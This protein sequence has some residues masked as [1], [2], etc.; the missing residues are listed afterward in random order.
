MKCEF[1]AKLLLHVSGRILIQRKN[2]WSVVGRGG[3]VFCMQP[4]WILEVQL[5]TRGATRNRTKSTLHILQRVCGK[6]NQQLTTYGGLD[7]RDFASEP[8]QTSTTIKQTG[9]GLKTGGLDEEREEKDFACENLV[10]SS[11]TQSKSNQLPLPS[12][13]LPGSTFP[14]AV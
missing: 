5:W 8:L 2:S 11:G 14:Q 6:F 3:S 4:K 9:Q 12:Q 7:N 13:H 1:L 10:S